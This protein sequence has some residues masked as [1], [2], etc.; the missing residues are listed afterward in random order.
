[1]GRWT[2]SCRRICRLRRGLEEEMLGGCCW[3][4]GVNGFGMCEGP[5]D[6]EIGRKMIEGR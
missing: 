1:M 2:R 3:G 4:E 6:W 5:R